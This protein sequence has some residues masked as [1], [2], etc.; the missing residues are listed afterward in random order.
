MSDDSQ[1]LYTRWHSAFLGFDLEILTYF[2]NLMA[3]SEEEEEEEG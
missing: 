1:V 2:E 3:K